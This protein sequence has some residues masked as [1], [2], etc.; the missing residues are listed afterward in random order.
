M[1]QQLNDNSLDLAA[2]LQ[3]EHAMACAAVDRFHHYAKNAVKRGT[4]GD[5]DVY[6]AMITYVMDR[7][8]KFYDANAEVFQLSSGRG[9]KST[10]SLRGSSSSSP[11]PAEIRKPSVPYWP[12]PPQH[13]DD[14]RVDG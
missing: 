9:R 10:S 12:E 11:P 4:A 3:H 6:S 14:L 8:L 7:C 5:V 13:V 2:E 1:S